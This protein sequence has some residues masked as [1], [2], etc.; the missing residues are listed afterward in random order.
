MILELI[1]ETKP[2]Q[3]TMYAVVKDGLTVKWFTTHTAAETFYDSVIT[4]PEL[5][6]TKRNILKSQEIDVSLDK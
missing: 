3:G 1:E 6:E 2:E 4:T 5:L